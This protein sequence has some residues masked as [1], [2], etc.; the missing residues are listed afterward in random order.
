MTQLIHTD[1]SVV[2]GQE[3]A[4]AATAVLI[5]IEDVAKILGCSTRHVRRLVNANRIPR[6]I[7]LVALLRWIKTDIDQWIATGCPSCRKGGVR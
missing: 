2:A 1:R 7:K 4:P 6:P 5:A 3:T